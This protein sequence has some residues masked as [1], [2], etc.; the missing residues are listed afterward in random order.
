[1]ALDVTHWVQRPDDFPCVDA[2]ASYERLEIDVGDAHNDTIKTIT[3]IG[4][5]EVGDATMIFVLKGGG[6]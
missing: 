5:V 2:Q 4:V 6:R 1:M 3:M